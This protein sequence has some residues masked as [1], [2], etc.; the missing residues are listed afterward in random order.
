MS[1][2]NLLVDVSKQLSENINNTVSDNNKTI[3][4]IV[5]DCRQKHILNFFK[6]CFCNFR[7]KIIIN[8]D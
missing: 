1:D 7:I 4:L 5:A 3:N 8:I 2:K 6:M